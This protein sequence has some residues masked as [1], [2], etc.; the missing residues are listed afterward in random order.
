[1]L[2]EWSLLESAFHRPKEGPLYARLHNPFRIT[3]CLLSTSLKKCAKTWTP[4]LG[5]F[6]AILEIKGPF[7]SLEILGQ[8]L[9]SKESRWPSIQ[10]SEGY[11]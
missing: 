7:S 11:Q 2:V 3:A 9:L 4:F 1:M 5:D 8:T 6:D 10:K